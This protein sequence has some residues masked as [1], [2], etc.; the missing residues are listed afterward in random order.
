MTLDP[1]AEALAYLSQARDALTDPSLD[2]RAAAIEARRCAGIADHALAVLM[3][4]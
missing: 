4:T 1:R 2:E 3:D